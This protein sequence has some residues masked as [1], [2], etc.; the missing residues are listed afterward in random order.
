[1]VESVGL[2]LGHLRN[3]ASGLLAVEDPTGEALFVFA[4]CLD[5]HIALAE[6]HHRLK[7]DLSIVALR[8]R[9]CRDRLPPCSAGDFPTR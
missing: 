6:T 5:A 2:A 9:R 7:N 8:M 1:M 4:E 3:A